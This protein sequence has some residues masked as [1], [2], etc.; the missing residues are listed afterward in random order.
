V[1]LQRRLGDHLPKK[2][3]VPNRLPNPAERD[4]DLVFGSPEQADRFELIIQQDCRRSS[5]VSTYERVNG[6]LEEAEPD[7]DGYRLYVARLARPL[8]WGEV[9][10]VRTFAANGES[11][12]KQTV[13]VTS[14]D[15][16]WGR[17]RWSGRIGSYTSRCFNTACDDSRRPIELLTGSLAGDF[18]VKPVGPRVHTGCRNEAPRL[19]WGFHVYGES[20]FRHYPF[21]S[22]LN[23][24]L[25]QSRW[26]NES[27]TGVYTPF[28][29]R[30]ESWSWTFRGYRIGPYIAPI[31]K[32]GLQG[33]LGEA[34]NEAPVGEFKA[35]YFATGV[36]VGYLRF[37]GRLPPSAGLTGYR[38]RPAPALLSH[39][40]LT[41]GKWQ[42]LAVE[43]GASS[44]RMPC[45]LK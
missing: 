20:G 26:G 34:K 33:G 28:L 23:D 18:A 22:R 9:L 8:A 38:D 7:K 16:S 11:L 15:Y 25:G 45:V 3:Q 35:P 6:L 13:V 41:W 14:S 32:G 42:S 36:R 44:Y 39:V 29:L 4:L 1:R 24:T 30:P 19:A 27:E 43:T 10:T 40:D 37:F 17:F 12:R 2:L 31:W 5:D 21:T